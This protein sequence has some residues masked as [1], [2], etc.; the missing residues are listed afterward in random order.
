MMLIKD[1]ALL[2]AGTDLADL[3]PSQKW[4]HRISGLKSKILK[5]HKEADVILENIINE[6]Q[7]NRA[8][9]MKGNSEFG[10]EDLVDVLLRVM[11]SGELGTAITNNNIKAVILVS[12]VSYKILPVSVYTCFLSNFSRKI[13]YISIFLA[14]CRTCL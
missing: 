10:G 13:R 9:G 2:A 4:L 3:F 1:I 11:E 14:T 5:V 8:N 12:L 6:H 7:E